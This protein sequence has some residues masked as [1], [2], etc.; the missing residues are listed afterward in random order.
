MVKTII[1]KDGR[2]VIPAKYRRALGLKPGDEVVLV[3]EGDEIRVVSTRR[4]I[5][6]AQAM[7]RRYI[8]RGRSLAQELIRERREETSGV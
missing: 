3:L 5:A 7:V 6:R 8:P 2:V 1:R 4:A